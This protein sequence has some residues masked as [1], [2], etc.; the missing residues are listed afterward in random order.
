VPIASS[1]GLVLPTR[2]TASVKTCLGIEHYSFIKDVGTNN[3]LEAITPTRGSVG[4][5]GSLAQRSS[6]SGATPMPA[7]PSGS[8]SAAD[9]NDI[10]LCVSPELPEAMRRPKWSSEDYVVLDQIHKGHSSTVFKVRM[11]GS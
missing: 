5:T 8:F 7:A 3:Y 11:C 4:A 10:L 1:P 9:N 2:R 6:R